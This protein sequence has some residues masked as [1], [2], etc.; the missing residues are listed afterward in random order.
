MRPASVRTR[1]AGADPPRAGPAGAIIAS[2]TSPIRRREIVGI[3]M[4]DSSVES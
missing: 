2:S 1:K 4:F 3:R